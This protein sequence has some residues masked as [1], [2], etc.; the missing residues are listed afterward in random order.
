MS[1]AGHDVGPLLGG[2]RQRLLQRLADLFDEVVLTE[3]P[4]WV[5]L[6]A[7]SGWGKTRLVQE[8]FGRLAAERQSTPAFWPAS[9][10]G[11]VVGGVPGRVEDRRKR[12]F[13]ER[14]DVAAERCRI[15]SGGG[16]RAR[17]ATACRRWRWPT[18]SG[19][20]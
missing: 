17:R 5:S 1:D 3:Q 16:C 20:S 6:E 18:T 11:A 13:P 14:F 12:V 7:E 4:R 8:L 19:S 2:E 15:G 9:I 10:P